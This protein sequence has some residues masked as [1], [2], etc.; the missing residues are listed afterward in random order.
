[1]PCTDWNNT[2]RCPRHPLCA[3]YHSPDE[4]REASGKQFDYRKSL[5]D[6]VAQL[7]ILQPGFHQPPLFTG[8]DVDNDALE[9]HG[10]PLPDPFGPLSI[11]PEAVQQEAASK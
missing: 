5:L 6:S 9:L 8:M 7:R 4:M 1:M 2:R 3:F 10:Q 11:A